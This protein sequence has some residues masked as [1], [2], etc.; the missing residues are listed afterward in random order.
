MDDPAR[1]RSMFERISTR[2]PLISVDVAA[3]GDAFAVV[4]IG[5]GDLLLSCLAA[6]IA[7]TPVL[8]VSFCG[9]VDSI[10]EGVLRVANSREGMNH[11]S[12]HEYIKQQKK[13]SVLT[14]DLFAVFVG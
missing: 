3:N 2:S 7:L 6:M 14:H 9:V 11:K 12:L 8:R 4:V 1:Q 13:D 5:T 10:L